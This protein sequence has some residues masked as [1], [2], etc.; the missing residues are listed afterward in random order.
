MKKKGLSLLVLAC[1]SRCSLAAAAG[2]KRSTSSVD[3][4]LGRRQHVRLAAR[5]DLDA[6]ARQRV[7]LHGPV[8]RV[9]SGGGITAISNRTV[10]FGASDAPL[11]PDQFCGLQRLRPDPVGARRHGD[12]VQR[13]GPRRA[14]EHEPEPLRRRDREDLHGR[15]HELERPGD[16]EA[17][18][19]GAT[20]PD[21]KIT[22]VYRTGN[23]GTTYNFTDYLAAVSPAWKSKLGTGQSVNWPTGIGASGS[24]GVAG[25]VANT[26]GA[27]LLRRHGV[28]RH[29]QAPLRGDPERGRASSS[30]RA[31][32]TSRRRAAR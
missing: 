32:A 29:E 24:A 9:G 18:P 13:P 14:E 31:S 23:S 16:Q 7:R 26:P 8:Q 19:E 27:H 21:L 22:P 11:T 6:G 15:D 20:L 25:V 5:V 4:D 30:T 12:P 17:E 2:A 28:R 3:D 1:A 10:D